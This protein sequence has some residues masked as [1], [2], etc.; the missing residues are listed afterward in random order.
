MTDDNVQVKMTPW[1]F[2]GIVLAVGF[3]IGMTVSR[4]TRRLT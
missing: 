2:I 4:I 1:Q 3:A